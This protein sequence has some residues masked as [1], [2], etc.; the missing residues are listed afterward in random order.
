MRQSGGRGGIEEGSQRG[1]RWEAERQRR[2]KGFASLPVGYCGALLCATRDSLDFLCGETRPFHSC[3]SRAS[4]LGAR[5]RLVFQR[6]VEAHP[7]SRAF[8]K[9]AR[10]ED[11]QS[12]YALAR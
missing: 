9:W 2:Q 5:V 11:K 12:Q 3:S 1:G 4:S 10:W 7:H 6:Y 8:L